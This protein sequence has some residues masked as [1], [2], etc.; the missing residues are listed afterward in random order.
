MQGDEAEDTKILD[1]SGRP[2]SSGH[3]TAASLA[4]G[5]SST[6]LKIRF[7][8]SSKGSGQQTGA[9]SP[10]SALPSAPATPNGDHNGRG[11]AA[12]SP[13]E[14]DVDLEAAAA[15]ERIKQDAD[16]QRRQEMIQEQ[17][18]RLRVEAAERERQT[19]EQQVYEESIREIPQI[20]RQ[21]FVPLYDVVR[22]AIARSYSELQSLVEV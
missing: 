19:H 6:K 13:M 15:A 2:R 22:R 7:G 20:A 16:E 3:G 4:A 8:G 21:H 9:G 14:M 17:Q 5:S 11:S 12:A 18:E 10:I 1:A